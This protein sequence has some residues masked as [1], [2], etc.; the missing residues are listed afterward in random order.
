MATPPYQH[1]VEQAR[2]YAAQYHYAYA[3]SQWKISLAPNTG[4]RGWCA[5][6]ETDVHE[7]VPDTYYQ[8]Y[9]EGGQEREAATKHE[10][11]PIF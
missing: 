1:G 9:T 4:F 8:P 7:R 2:Y 6:R 11:S 3:E 10:K 5:T